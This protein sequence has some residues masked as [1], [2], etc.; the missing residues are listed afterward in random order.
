MEGAIGAM[1][2]LGFGV[3]VFA[4]VA[5]LWAGVHAFGRGSGSASDQ[6]DAVLI[7]KAAF[8]DYSTERPGTFHKIT[9]ADLPPPFATGSAINMAWVIDRP[10]G[11]W[12]KAL[13]G[14]KVDLYAS[15]L[16]NP[17]LIRT[18]PN[19]DIFLAESAPGNIK[20]L[21]G[22]DSNGKAAQLELFACGLKEPFGIA[23]YP[24]GPDPQWVYV[25]NTDSVVRFPYKNG[26]MKAGGAQQ[27]IVPDL[28]GGGRLTGGGHWTRDIAFS[29]D[30]KK[31]Y[32]SVGSHSNV[33]DTDNNPQEDH[34][35]D[36][37]EFNPDGSGF[38][39]YAYGIRNAVG[40]A[41]NPQTGELWGSVNERDGLGDD[42]PPDYI[43]HIQ[44][45]GFYGWP[46]FYM[47]GTWDPRH[48]GKHPELKNKVLTPDVLLQ[49][50]FA[51]LEMTFYDGAQFPA[52]YRGDVFASEH[53]SWNRKKR[54]GYEVIRVPLKNG[55]ATGEYEDFLT[56]FATDEGKVWGR[57]VGVAV[58]RDGSL[59]VS[60]DGSKSIWRV[61]YTG[62]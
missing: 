1:K 44:D 42:L 52:E 4:S 32:V 40:I 11:A 60:D 5:G 3:L 23:F 28:P 7:G 61:S 38:R 46:W 18:A 34:R 59:F 14:F 10:A 29:R 41:T 16:K 31:M 48:Q 8:T 13:P 21:R 56:G 36:V 50:H 33:D 62:K 20:V 35:A 22:I 57:P 43:T 24:P 2:F 27:V 25:G 9:V 26:N 47:G 49:P 54:T 45:G 15:G 53:G 37:L 58:G 39:V 6:N 51:S 30:G 17:R 12:P 19:G 55:H